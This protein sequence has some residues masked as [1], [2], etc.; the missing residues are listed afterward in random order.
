MKSRQGAVPKIAG[1]GVCCLDHIFVAP[2]IAWGRTTH[3]E[4]YRVQGGGLVG[5]ALVACAR[6]G[7]Q[8]RLFSYLG[9]DDVGIRVAA[10]LAA[11][12]ISL[13]GVLRALRNSSPFSFIHVDSRT[14]ERTIFHRPA[15]VA[16]DAVLPDF[17]W[18]ARADAL[19]IDD[20]YP[21][22]SL[23]A[24]QTA[25]KNGV[26]VVADTSINPEERKELF[27]HIDV[28]IIPR[29]V[30]ERYGYSRSLEA[31]VAA[32]H[33]LGPPTIVITL[34]K[35]GWVFSSSAG[36]GRGKAFKVDVL[37]TTGAGD[38]FHGAFAYALARGWDVERCS[39]FAGAVAAIK[40]TRI[41]GRTGLPS[42]DQTLIFLKR[43]GRLDW[44]GF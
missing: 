24:A 40:C 16:E 23:A 8:C 25:R 34:G 19:L 33:K 35:E 20:Y 2:Q 4:D 13:A 39:E 31:A 14:G 11:E 9:N 27:A 41:G 6:L 3:V 26:P 18:I 10:E 43:K 36:R 29:S 37:D 44:A 17:G 28:L 38:A 32:I 30:A 21:A 1:A 22:L 7:A 15:L 12:G 42:L 5:T